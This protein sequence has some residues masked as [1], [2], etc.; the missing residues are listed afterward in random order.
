MTIVVRVPSRPQRSGL[1]AVFHPLGDGGELSLGLDDIDLRDPIE[2]LLGD[3]RF[4]GFPHIEE[5]PAAMRR[6]CNG[7]GPKGLWCSVLADGQP[8]TGGAE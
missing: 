4:R 7:G 2:R 5:L 6:R 1:L 8:V 3:R